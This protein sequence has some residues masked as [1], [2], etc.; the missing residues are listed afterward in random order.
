MGFHL[1]KITINLLLP[2]GIS[3]NVTLSLSMVEKLNY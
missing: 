1:D 3:F 2:V